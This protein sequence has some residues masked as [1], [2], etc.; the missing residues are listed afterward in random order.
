MEE[1][2]KKKKEIYQCIDCDQ[3]TSD[4]YRIP[5]NRGYITKCAKCYELWISRATR[6]NWNYGTNNGKTNHYDE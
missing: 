4:Y 1:K 6:L 5:T 3:P 2:D